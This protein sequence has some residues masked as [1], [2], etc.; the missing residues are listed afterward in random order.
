MVC[1]D[2]G[3]LSDHEGL[4]LGKWSGFG[5]ESVEPWWFVGCGGVLERSERGKR[6]RLI[7]LKKQFKC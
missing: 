2:T 3:E 5:D 1:N 4:S 7:K 6:G